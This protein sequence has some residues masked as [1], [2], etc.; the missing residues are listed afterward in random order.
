M[1]GYS[2]VKELSYPRFSE[3]TAEL[4]NVVI[5]MGYKRMPG[6]APIGVTYS[7]LN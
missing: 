2:L 5:S 1:F 6:Y 4:H 3:L 7:K